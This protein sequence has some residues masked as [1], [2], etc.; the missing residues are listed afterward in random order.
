MVS[1]H[2]VRDVRDRR[3]RHVARNA[4]IRPSPRLALDG[5]KAQPFFSWQCETTVAVVRDLR[6]RLR[7]AVRVVAGDAAKLT[8]A[9]DET[10]TVF[11]SARHARPPQTFPGFPSS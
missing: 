5:G 4:V 7:Q 1:R 11:P 3:T 6:G 8:L 10:A 9:L 2:R